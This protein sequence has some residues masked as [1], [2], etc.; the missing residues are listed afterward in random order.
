MK[1]IIISGIIFLI[2]GLAIGKFFLGGTDSSSDSQ[3]RKI[4]YY[5][6]PMNPANTSPTPKKA[7]DG[8]DFVPV[9]EDQKG[10]SGQK[11]IAYYQDPMHPWFTSDKPGTAPD[12]G[13]DLV[14][15]YED[16]ENVEGIKIDPV[17]VQNIGVRIETVKKQKLNNV[18]RTTGKVDFDETKVTTITTKIMGWVEKLFVDYT[19]KYISKGQPLFEI[20]SPELVST[21]EEY[22]QAI[23]YLKKVSNSS[24]D[25]KNGA[26]ELINSAKRRLLY[27]DISEKDIDEIEKNNTPKKTLTI[28]SPVNGTVVDKMVFK[29]Q[30]IMAGM[31]LYKVADLSNVWGMAD[32]YQV[33]LPLIKHGK[34]V[35]LELSYLAGK[36]YK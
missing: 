5:Q 7:P 24:D 3:E 29:G 28:Y 25:V 33:D 16:D 11:K 32:I 36:T 22:L 35:D 12:C 26:Q 23:R 27:W 9:Y 19:G 18:I 13:M 34:K 8:M 10:G 1:K 21:Q 30:Q 2:V 31:E 14:P 15:V 20:Y 17:T 6:D 4:L